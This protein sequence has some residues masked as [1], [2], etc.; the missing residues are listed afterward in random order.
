M[1]ILV[2]G[3]KGF[4]GKNL[5]AELRNKKNIE[6]YEYHRNSSIQDLDN[7][8]RD[9]D[10]VFHLAGINRPKNN[11][12]YLEG[13]FG[14]TLYLIKMLKKHKNKST[15]MFS[16]STQAKL[17]NP[18]GQSKNLAENKLFEY[19]KENNVKVL[20]YRLTNVFGK[21]CKPNYNS[22]VATF[23]HN[24]ANGLPIK[25]NDPDVVMNLIYID[26]LVKELINSLSGNEN[27]KGKFCFVEPIYT[28]KLKE[29]VDLLNTFKFSRNDLLIPNTKNDFT[30]KLYTTYLSYLQKESLIYDLKMNIDNR[31]SFTEFF[32][33]P[34]RGQL[35]INIIK[36][37][38]IK[39]NHYHHSKNEKF[40]I[41]SGEGVIRLRKIYENEIINLDVNGDKLQV[42]DIPPGYTH[43]IENTGLIDMI[44]VIWVN[45]QYDP[46]NPDT[47]Y[48]EV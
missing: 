41:V 10:F 21:W 12:E 13:N 18:Y 48:M 42:V 6:I 16:S 2:T 38:I 26:D 31:G 19:S 5:I 9:C 1:K 44:V 36:P 25:L 43:N 11:N 45:E 34:E 28:I 29:I 17:N 24:I 23:S 7:Y 46:E 47:F 20:V 22:V 30:K 37:G 27:I 39:G 35:S 14:L 40:I 32:K 33:S 4:I 8:T 15:I 3:A